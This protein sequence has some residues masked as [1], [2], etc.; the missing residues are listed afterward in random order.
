MTTR[1]K[2]ALEAGHPKALPLVEGEL[3]AE[4]AGAHLQLA[5]SRSTKELNHPLQ[6][7]GAAS[8]LLLV[9]VDGDGHE[10]V[11]SRAEGLHDA[12]AHRL[13]VA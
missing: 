13:P 2:L 7:R 3:I 1:F 11:D 5:G 10:L 4:R 8:G 6:Q 12:R 9:R